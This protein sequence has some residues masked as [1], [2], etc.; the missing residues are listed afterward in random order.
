MDSLLLVFQCSLAVGGANRTLYNINEVKVFI[1]LV[2]SYQILL[3]GH[4]PLPKAT[5]PNRTSTTVGIAHNRVLPYPLE[6]P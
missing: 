3:V 5:T 2:P 4:V 6:F 1:H